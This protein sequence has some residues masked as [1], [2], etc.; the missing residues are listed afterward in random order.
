MAG[1]NSRSVG[2]ERATGNKAS[3]ATGKGK[4]CRRG[5]GLEGGGKAGGT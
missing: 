4:A 3:E 5:G 2:T 1:V